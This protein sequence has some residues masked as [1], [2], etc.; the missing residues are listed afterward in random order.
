ML[1]CRGIGFRSRTT[2]GMFTVQ[3]G[4]W[5]YRSGYSSTISTTLS[6]TQT[7]AVSHGTRRTG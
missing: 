5:M 2:D 6:R 4:V 3:L 7:M 1:L